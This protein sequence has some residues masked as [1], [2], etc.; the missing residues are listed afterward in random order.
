MKSKDVATLDLLEQA[1]DFCLAS[2]KVCDDKIIRQKI[3]DAQW[4]LLD[5]IRL[6]DQKINKE[7]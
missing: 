3:L 1:D 6:L 2:L 5:A 4:E 7:K